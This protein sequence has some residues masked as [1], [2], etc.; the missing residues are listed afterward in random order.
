MN[1]NVDGH[2]LHITSPLRSEVLFDHSC[3]NIFHRVPCWEWFWIVLVLEV[4]YTLPHFYI[5]PISIPQW[6]SAW[7]ICNLCWW[8]SIGK[9][10]PDN[11]I[12]M[13][14]YSPWISLYNFDKMCITL[15]WMYN[16]PHGKYL[17]ALRQFLMHGVTYKIFASVLCLNKF[18][19]GLSLS[20]QQQNTERIIDN[21]LYIP[22][23]IFH[24]WIGINKSIMSVGAM[25]AECHKYLQFNY[26]SGTKAPPRSLWTE[27]PY[28]KLCCY[29]YGLFLLGQRSMAWHKKGWGEWLPNI[30]Q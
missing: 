7:D 18:I 22:S 10:L 2:L 25:R 13:Q 28:T 23:N 26:S 1:V 20:M 17:I 14:R 4:L 3:M 24:Q 16:F 6:T 5:P 19:P 29:V 27:T 9:I 12:G 8:I 11:F 15:M 30:S 21:C